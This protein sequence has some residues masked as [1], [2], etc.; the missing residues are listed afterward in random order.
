MKML[1]QVL[2]LAALSPFL[3]CASTAYAATPITL[4]GSFG[5]WAGK[6]HIEDPIGDTDVSAADVSRLYF[7][8]NDDDPSMYFMVERVQ[9]PSPTVHTLFIDVNNNGLFEDPVDAQIRVS[10]H[11]TGQ[12]TVAVFVGTQPVAVYSGRWGDRAPA[13]ALR[14]EWSV[15]FED[16]NISPGQVIRLVLFTTT[17]A[18]APEDSTFAN[19]MALV[20]AG[21]SDRVPDTGDLQWAPVPILSL[22]GNAALYLFC[23]LL[24]YRYYYRRLRVPLRTTFSTVRR[25]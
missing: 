12:V 13:G 20:E 21:Q 18:L 24:A 4:D 25:S 16:L 2:V 23:C 6:P 9:V 3:L 22:W 8:N 19:H 11:P 5:D 17:Q 10:H 15:P 7:A 14:C 1:V